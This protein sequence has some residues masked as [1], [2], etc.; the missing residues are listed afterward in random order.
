MH[1]SQNKQNK[2]K[3]GEKTINSYL[4]MF[5]NEEL[6]KLIPIFLIAKETYFLK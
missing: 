4:K 5:K 2:Q 3:M 1:V 6:H